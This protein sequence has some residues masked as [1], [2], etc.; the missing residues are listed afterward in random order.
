MYHTPI[1]LSSASP[2]AGAQLSFASEAADHT[3]VPPLML[4]I[5]TLENPH[6][7]WT[8]SFATTSLLDGSILW[9]GQ[10]I[11][12]DFGRA[13]PAATAFH[14]IAGPEHDGRPGSTSSRIST[15][16]KIWLV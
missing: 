4:T 8:H 2:H 16:D 14:G 13:L 12:L 5:D 11:G 9:R 7:N 3:S 15:P 1:A 6:Y 10:V